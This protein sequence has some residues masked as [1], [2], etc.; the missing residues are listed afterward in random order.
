MKKVLFLTAALAA[1]VSCNKTL[2]GYDKI[3]Y[4]PTDNPKYNEF[5]LRNI[6][7]CLLFDLFP[8]SE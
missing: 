6:V 1:L 2:D 8:V 7:D 5:V 4:I 3:L